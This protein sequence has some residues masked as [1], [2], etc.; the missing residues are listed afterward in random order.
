MLK[1]FIVL[2]LTYPSLKNFKG[3][4]CALII[5]IIITINLLRQGVVVI[6]IVVRLLAP[7]LVGWLAGWLAVWLVGRFMGWLVGWL[8][9]L[10]GFFTT[11]ACSDSLTAKYKFASWLVRFN[12]L[13]GS[14][15]SC[16]D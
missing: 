2:K 4:F 3:L 16:F 9:K 8:T 13:H 14:L 7:R 12:G 1:N 10:T 15:A 6:C 11:S 5:I